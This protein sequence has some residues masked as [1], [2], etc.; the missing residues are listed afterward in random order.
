MY[1]FWKILSHIFR[2]A[3]YKQLSRNLLKLVDLSKTAD[4]LDIGAANIKLKFE[5]LPL[6]EHDPFT[7]TVD[8]VQFSVSYFLMAGSIKLFNGRL[9]FTCERYLLNGSFLTMKAS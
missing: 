4:K 6:T 5:A 7:F 3:P 9:K 8:V 2:C 1:N